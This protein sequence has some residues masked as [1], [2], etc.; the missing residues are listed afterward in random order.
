MIR[1]KEMNGKMVLGF[2]EIDSLV[3][4]KIKLSIFELIALLGCT[5]AA[6][7]MFY[8]CFFGTALVDEAY[9]VSDALAM[10]HG[11][12]PYVYNWFAGC[13][14]D[15]LLIPFLFVYE[16]FVPDLEGVFLFSRIC[17]VLFRLIILVFSFFLIKKHLKK[18][19]ALLLICAMIPFYGGV[20]QNFS[21]HTIPIWM[22]FL[23]GLLLWGAADQK[24]CKNIYYLAAGFCSAIAVFAHPIYAINILLFMGLIIIYDKKVS[25]LL[26]YILGGVIEILIVF[27]PLIAQ[28]GMDKVIFGLT[29]ILNGYVG[30]GNSLVKSTPGSRIL[31]AFRAFYLFWS[32]E[33][34]VFASVYFLQRKICTWREIKLEKDSMYALACLCAVGVGIATVMV[35]NDFDLNAY[36]SLGAVGSLG[37]LLL[38]KNG[39]KHKEI[40]CIGLPPFLFAWF[41]V[42][43]TGSNGAQIRFYSCILCFFCILWMCFQESGRAVH[44]M[45]AMLSVVMIILQCYIDFNYVYRDD[46]FRKLNY[47]VET[48]VYKGIYTSND[49]AHDLPELENYLDT[50]VSDDELIAFRDNAPCAYLMKNQNICDV[51]TWD[52]LQYGRG[53][54]RPLRM[55]LYYKAK[56]MIPDKIIYVDFGRTEK[57]SIEDTD[58][59]YNEFVEH[60]YTLVDDRQINT[61]F[62]VKLYEN[63]DT[64]DGDYD[65][66]IDTVK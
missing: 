34:I 64:F 62:R 49:R 45:A 9:Y 25:V 3:Q 8:R 50:V 65:Y 32:V 54:K 27:I 17:F 15:F 43:L 2:S 19:H 55:Y 66:W 33:L 21:Y 37:F 5:C 22:G 6:A 57:L 46:P 61:T 36:C 18:I 38:M 28:G 47:K 26:W 20:I 48:G 4:R 24:R 44:L 11:N 1:D 31:D 14:M 30:N 53:N 52:T 39:R 41:E 56:G 59:P 51:W 63:N 13:G 23:T 42:F 60:Y 10:L 29:Y 7:L 16:C 58:F 35:L 12:L 40:V